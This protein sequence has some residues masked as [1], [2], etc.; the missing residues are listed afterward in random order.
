MTKTKIY[1]MKKISLFMLVCAVTAA[2]YAQDQPQLTTPMTVK[3]RIGIKGGVNLATLEI[4]DQSTPNMNT[5]MK[6]SFHGGVFANIPISGGFRFQ[7]EAMYS[8][9]GTK[10][11]VR[12]S[13]DAHL[14]GINEYDFRYI[15]VP[16]MLQ[17]MSTAGVFVELGPQ[18]SYLAKANGDRQNDN[19][20]ELKNSDYVKKTDFA[21]A[22][23]IGYLSRVGLG[24][25]ARYVNGFSNVWNNDKSISTTQDAKYKN[26]VVQLSLIYHIGAGK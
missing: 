12:S 9:Q 16:L 15:A 1:F 8:G 13:T 23:G 26:R 5:N 6:T 18:F 11:S 24:L 19:S 17:W 4:D 3:P 21:G 20:V 25:N 2:S 22:A 14:A 10:S 7:P